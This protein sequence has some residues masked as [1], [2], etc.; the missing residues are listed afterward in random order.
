MS[1]YAYLKHYQYISTTD[2]L[3]MD[4]YKIVDPVSTLSTWVN[5]FGDALFSWAFHKTSNKQQAED[6]VQETF[7]S[8]LKS[9]DSFDGKSNP[10]TWLFSILNNKIIDYYRKASTRME[11]LN[12]SENKATYL[13]TESLFDHN[14]NWKANG[15]EG[16][17]QQ[18]EN[19]MDNPSFEG[20]FAGC[21]DDLPED[22]R[23]AISSKYLL[24]KNATEICQELSITTSNYW[25]VI[26]RA[27]L[28]LKKCLEV[29][30]FEKL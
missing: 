26:H 2:N 27:K 7:L 4:S 5:D 20:V 11:R 21:M 18:D 16:V 30:W 6:L 29:G 14:D 3:D 15:L 24:E 12:S 22:W 1:A 17:W 23:I 19:L 25:Q 13:V 8:A 28:L 10:K 9:F